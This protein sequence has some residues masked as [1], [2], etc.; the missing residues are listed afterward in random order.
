MNL[1]TEQYQ[2][3]QGRCNAAMKRRPPQAPTPAKIV[4]PAPAVKRRAISLRGLNKTEARYRDL[5]KARGRTLILEQAIT[6]SLDPPFRSYRPDLAFI[7]PAGALWLYE[8]KGPHRFRRAG[9]AKVA[10]AAKTY[11]MFQFI[12]AEWT[13]EGWKET[14][15]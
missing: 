4:A 3:L 12:L 8:V 5:L 15:L 10:L 9:I 11:P 1:T 2:A 6:L 7:D 13:K 14:S